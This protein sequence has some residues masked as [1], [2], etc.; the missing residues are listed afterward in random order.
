MAIGIVGNI[1]FRS[2]SPILEILEKFQGLIVDKI[3][4]IDYG[5]NAWKVSFLL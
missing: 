5:V 2:S 4:F 1:E 3:V